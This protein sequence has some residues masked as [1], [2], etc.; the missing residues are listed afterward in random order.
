MGLRDRLRKFLGSEE[1]D[2]A[3]HFYV[4]CDRCGARLH[5]RVSKQYDLLPDYQGDA[6]YILHKEMMD[7]RCFTL[8]YAT[9]RFDKDYNVL[10]AE[11]EGGRF[12]SREEFEAAEEGSS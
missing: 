7:D 8:M 9:V 10:S 4:Q 2:D 6:A 11:I 12:I 3:L 1:A 5:I